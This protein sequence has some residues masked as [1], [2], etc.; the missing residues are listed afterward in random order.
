MLRK[1]WCEGAHG[2]HLHTLLSPGLPVY[3]S[4][5]DVQ[6]NKRPFHSYHIALGPKHFSVSGSFPEVTL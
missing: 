5:E 2:S 3:V 1:G 6:F 4:A